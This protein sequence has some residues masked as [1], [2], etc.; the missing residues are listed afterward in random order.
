MLC[1][2]GK[3][4]HDEYDYNEKYKIKNRLNP[5]MGIDYD[6]SIG[7]PDYRRINDSSILQ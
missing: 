4:K 3:R 2:F 7:N 6:A 1:K 5:N